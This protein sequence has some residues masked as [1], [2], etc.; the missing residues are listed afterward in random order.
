MFFCCFY[1][2][3]IAAGVLGMAVVLTMHGMCRG[4]KY[5]QRYPELSRQQSTPPSL[6][7]RIKY[8]Y[9]LFAHTSS[10]PENG[11]CSKVYQELS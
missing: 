11:T 5:L 4:Q 6:F 10:L 9:Q 8:F 1:V 7:E 3:S 2:M